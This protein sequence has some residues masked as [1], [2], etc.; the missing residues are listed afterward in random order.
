MQRG[1]VIILSLATAIAL[2]GYSAVFTAEK[3]KFGTSLKT[4]PHHVLPVIAAEEKGFWRAQGAEVE[5]VPFDA[6]GAM[7]R[8]VAAGQVQM[9]LSG[10][11]S[12]LRSAA[13]GVPIVIVADMQY[14]GNT[15]FWVRSDSAVRKPEDLKGAKIGV[16][17]FGGMIDAYGRFMAKALGLEG[18]VKF[19]A[20]GG[21]A[22]QIAAMRAGRL[23]AST[24]EYFPMAALK[25]E[26]VVREV[27][28]IQQLLPQKW[29]DL[30]IFARNDL[31]N[32][33]PALVKKVVTGILQ[34]ADFLQEKSDWAVEKMKSVSGYSESC[35]RD[36]YKLLHYGK[37]GRIDPQVIENIRRFIIDTGLLA[38]E[39]MPPTRMLYITKITG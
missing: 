17:V 7:F 11:V 5:W 25:C 28:G 36:S 18:Q 15:Y 16:A 29:S 37:D 39:K 14:Q 8:A 4:A 19:V 13:V 33:N 35:A 1:I 31:V 32:N 21:A 6:G 12:T 3:I 30:I 2:G 27:V 38:E 34:G 26:G 10:S 23:D 24:S 9:G 20:G 22:Q